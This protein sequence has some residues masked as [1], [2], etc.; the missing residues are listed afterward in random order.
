[1][2]RQK[3]TVIGSAFNNGTYC[4]SSVTATDITINNAGVFVSE[5]AGPTVT[6]T[7]DN[8]GLLIVPTGGIEQSESQ[9]ADNQDVNGVPLDNY[10]TDVGYPNTTSI[11]VGL[12]QIN[13]WAACNGGGKNSIAFDVCKRDV[14]GLNT[15]LLFTSGQSIYLTAT[16]TLI[17]IQWTV[18]TAIPLLATDRIV[19]RV[20]AFNGDAAAHTI[21]WFYQGN[22]HA[23][24]LD[25]T[26]P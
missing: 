22:L 5:G 24:Y 10:L 4:I 11:P 9:S 20:L 18:T 25:T 23:S 26:L 13:A 16:S 19:V 1:M 15:V 21:T 3:F 8:E 6:L 14:T 2:S 12:W 7:V 17:T